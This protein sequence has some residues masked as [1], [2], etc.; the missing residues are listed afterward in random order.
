[1][2]MRLSLNK[3]STWSDREVADRSRVVARP[4]AP[5]ADGASPTGRSR[6]T[7]RTAAVAVLLGG[8]AA[9]PVAAADAPASPRLASHGIPIVSAT[10]RRFDDPSPRSR[11][12]LPVPP[13]L[14]ASRFEDSRSLRTSARRRP[15]RRGLTLVELLV[16]IGVAI[17]LAAIIVPVTQQVRAKASEAAEASAARSVLAAWNLYAFEQRGRILPGYRNGLPAYDERGHSIAPQTI[18]VAA[19]RY[20]WRIAPYLG[21]SVEELFSPDVKRSLRAIEPSDRSEYLYRS[22]LLPRF[23]LN[24]TFVGGDEG[25]GGFSAAFRTVFGDF[26][27]QSLG[28]LVR[29]QE[30]LALASAASI[31]AEST[32]GRRLDGWFRLRAP[33]FTEPVWSDPIDAADPASSGHLAPRREDRCI[34]G[35]ADGHVEIRPIETLRDMRLWADQADRADWRLEPR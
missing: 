20:P 24:G 25:Y 30:V 34:A 1:M 26:Y 16:V 6:R 5:A 23:G 32:D 18:G 29:P 8:R 7:R 17:S 9:C 22:S 15:L 13:T 28:E 3:G 11:R 14:L 31:D 10:A 35:F 21:N 2:R 33:Q 27:R 12:T 19:A 4:L